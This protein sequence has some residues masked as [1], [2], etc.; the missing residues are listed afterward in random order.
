M[1]KRL[2]FGL[3]FCDLLWASP[4]AAQGDGAYDALREQDLRL[5]E[6]SERVLAANNDVCTERMPLTGMILHSRDQY[7]A[8]PQAW[9]VDGD[10]AIAAIVPGSPAERAGLQTN[11]VL[12][13]IG[14]AE[15]AALSPAEGAPLRDAAFEEIAQ[16]EDRPLSLTVM[17]NGGQIAVDVE[18]RLG[19]KALVEVLSDSGSIARSDGRVIQ[20]SQGLAASLD[21]AQLATVFAHELAHSVLLHRRRLEAAGVSKGLLGEFGRNQQLNRQVEVEADRLSVHLLA[22]A[23]YDPAI[24]SQFWRSE[25]GRRVDSGILRSW[26]Y[27]SASGRAELLKEEMRLYLPARQG[28]SWPGH[29]LSRRNRP[30]A[31]D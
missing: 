24:A 2:C 6:I 31:T 16:A 1:L 11:D 26:T 20:V 12:L 28:P 19:C 23:G 21:D 8:P 15:T 17:R 13:L 7:A 29:L 27:P 10:V 18:S 25:A 30:F 14:G 3:V 9:F 5:A 22:N 4:L